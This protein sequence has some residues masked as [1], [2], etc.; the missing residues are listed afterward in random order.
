MSSYVKGFGNFFMTQR[1]IASVIFIFLIFTCKN[2]QENPMNFEVHGIDVSHFQGEIDWP[3]V[4]DQG[5]T[6]AFVK[7][8]EGLYHCDTLF[9]KNWKSI[10]RAD[11]IRGAYHFFTPDLD[12]AQQ[13]QNFLIN[14]NL[15]NGDLPPVLDMEITDHHDP[16]ALVD[17][18]REWIDIVSTAYNTKPI[19]Y[20]NLKSYFRFIAGRFDENPV[21]IARY[22]DKIPDL[23][24]SKEW[25]FWQYNEK[26]KLNGIEDAVDLNAFNGSYQELEEMCL[27]NIPS[28][29]LLEL[30]GSK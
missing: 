30:V 14:V 5:V 7:A 11:M 29:E 19:I 6:F 26:G 25:S 9:Y 8:T 27:K 13:A 10:K 3:Q 4:K 24:N 2:V 15:Q 23:G 21:W 17:D 22:K 20:T 16:D 12:A 28:T 18:I 1:L